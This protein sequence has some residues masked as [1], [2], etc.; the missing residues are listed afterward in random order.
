MEA[1]RG[2]EGYDP[3]L[4]LVAEVD[5]AVVGHLLFTPCGIVVVPGHV[6]YYPRFGFEPAGAHGIT[7]PF[8]ALKESK[9]V[10]ALIPGALDGVGGE[11]RYPV[12]FLA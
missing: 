2:I 11:V 9:M 7:V 8:G 10:L 3:C 1:L 5:G 12:P 4:S 6:A